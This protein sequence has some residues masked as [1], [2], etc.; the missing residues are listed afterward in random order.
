MGGKSKGRAKLRSVRALSGAK[1]DLPTGGVPEPTDDEDVPILPIT[2]D[3]GDDRA[4]SPH[5]NNGTTTPDATATVGPQTENQATSNSAA[6]AMLDDVGHASAAPTN[7][8]RQVVVKL[9]RN[10]THVQ[11]IDYEKRPMFCSLCWC[12]GHQDSNCRS[13]RS[14]NLTWL[15]KHRSSKVEVPPS[16][17]DPS[18]ETCTTTSTSE[19]QSRSISMTQSH[20]K[21][22][23]EEPTCRS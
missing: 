2:E 10:H 7:P 17:A 3:E 6:P 18:T 15:L 9:P 4:G 20:Y 14:S 21:P 19:L 22:G 5:H 8:L 12:V 23:P 13:R 1:Q 16:A 11:H